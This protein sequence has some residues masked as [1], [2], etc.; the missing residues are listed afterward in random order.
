M[1]SGVVGCFATF[2]T[3][4]EVRGFFARGGKDWIPRFAR[5][6]KVAHYAEWSGQF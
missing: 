1:Q 3:P 2:V 4:N 6:D 5:N